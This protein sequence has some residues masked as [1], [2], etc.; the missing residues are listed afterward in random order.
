MYDNETRLFLFDQEDFDSQWFDDGE[1]LTYIIGGPNSEI[2]G[3]DNKIL[4]ALNAA[5]RE[6]AGHVPEEVADALGL[7]PVGD[8]LKRWNEVDGYYHA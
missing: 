5:C 1:G 7:T 3:P 6:N 2:E 8:G 4:D